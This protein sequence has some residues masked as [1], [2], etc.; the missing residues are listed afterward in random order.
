[1]WIMPQ[2]DAAIRGQTPLRMPM[3]ELVLALPRERLSVLCAW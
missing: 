1:M 2:L 3:E